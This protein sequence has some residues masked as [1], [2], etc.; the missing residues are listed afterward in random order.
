MTRSPTR[1]R[2]TIECLLNDQEAVF[3]PPHSQYTRSHL[4]VLRSQERIFNKFDTNG[5][6]EI[7]V[8]EL[9]ATFASIGLNASHSDVLDLF[10]ILDS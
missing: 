1:T 6:G 5:T 2:S 10:A 4:S 3:Q 9:R 8:D 7:S